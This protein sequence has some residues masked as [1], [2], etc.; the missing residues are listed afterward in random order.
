M[1]IIAFFGI[2][3]AGKT[4]VANALRKQD[5]SIAYLG[6]GDLL[7]REI[8]NKTPFGLDYMQKMANGEMAPSEKTNQLVIDEITKLE[9]SGKYSIL[10]LDGFPRNAEQLEFSKEKIEIEVGVHFDLRDPA[11]VMDRLLNRKREDDTEDVIIKRMKIFETETMPVINFYSDKRKMVTVDASKSSDYAVNEVM[12]LINGINKNSQ[13]HKVATP[14]REMTEDEVASLKNKLDMTLAEFGLKD[15]IMIVKN[16]DQHI[17]IG[18]IEQG[19]N[20]EFL[21][22]LISMI[23]NQIN[24]V[25]TVIDNVEDEITEIQLTRILAELDMIRMNYIGIMDNLDALEQSD[26][27]AGPETEE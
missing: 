12:N 18:S 17:N 11:I 21:S 1:K 13:S 7:R 10:I 5:T 14:V 25:A 15:Y 4:T 26:K 22:V 24:V 20:Q 9:N 3:G 23:E 27:N 16:G 6:A 2:N 8:Q 19:T